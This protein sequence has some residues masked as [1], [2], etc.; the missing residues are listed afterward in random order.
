MRTLENKLLQQGI[1]RIVG[2]DEV[3]RGPLAG[4]VVAAAVQVLPASFTYEIRDSKQL[5]P[6][7]R[8]Q[9]YEEILRTCH[10]GVGLASVEEIDKLNILQATFL[11]MRRALADLPIEPEFCLVDGNLEIPEITWPQKA[12]VKGDHLSISVA[13]ASIV[14]KVERDRIMENYHESYPVYNFKKN[15][16]YPTKE[17]RDALQAN[18]RSPVHRQSFRCAGL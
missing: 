15:K 18:G 9:A 4:P 7:K 8:E 3:G 16:G 6:K 11:A 13:A 17:H 12:I 14:A 5:S 10:V 1:T 2:V